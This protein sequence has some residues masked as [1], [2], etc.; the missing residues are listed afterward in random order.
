[1]FRIRRIHDDM[2]PVNIAALSQVKEILR[3]QI[4]GLTVADV[5]SIGNRLRDPIK[6]RFRTILYVADN[7][8]LKVLG[9]ALVMHDPGLHMF[10]LDSIAT[11][12]G[13]TSR[14][15]GGSLYQHVREEALGFGCRGLF[16]ECLPDERKDCADASGLAQ[17]RSRLRFYE[18]FGA[19]PLIGTTYNTPVGDRDEC[20]PYL[21]FDG[22]DASS[23]PRRQFVKEAIRAILERKYGDICTPGYVK[24]VIDS[25]R[26]D[27]V[28]LRPPRYVQERPCITTTASS[29]ERI[30]LVVNDSHDIHHVHDRGYVEAP[31]RVKRILEELDKTD[32]FERLP[33]REHS[34]RPIRAVHDRDFVDYL[35]RVCA[36]V[37]ADK[38]IYPYV[39]PI[40]NNTRPPK[41]LPVRAGYYCIDTF[42][43]LNRNAFLAARGAVDCALT[44]AAEIRAGRRLAY[45][46]VRPPGHHAERRSFGGFC[47]FNNVAVAA[48]ELS[49][50]GKI[51]I[52]DIDYH[53]G[54]GQQD[55]FFARRD[56]LTVSIHG[57]PKFAYPYFSGFEDEI[58]RGHGKGFNLNLPQSEHL[59]G[60]RYRRALDKALKRIRDFKPT[61]LLVSLGLD[62]AKGDP[63]G[64]WNLTAADF[65]ENG[66]RIGCLQLP[67]LVIQEGGYRTRTLGISARH[68]FS[69]LMTGANES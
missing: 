61:A 38:S 53:H 42:T 41:E 62:T 52:L 48:Q 39:F 54:N 36:N 3:E 33:A 59:D 24:K 66:R 20:P 26:D 21:V 67:T 9:F 45:A 27:P 69:G 35:Q 16:L 44:A 47:Y 37:P 55:I 58:G 6:H 8:G 2:L 4:P 32:L 18:H 13:L 50:L 12:S 49:S 19:R 17:N 63:T 51:A 68:F 46:L 57:N 30:A 23:P 29:R 7:K 11:A 10:Y 34:L 5:N 65:Q 15:V 28:A 43:P 31:V 40:R 25:V 22:L 64:T 1:M 14:G 56:V 60:E